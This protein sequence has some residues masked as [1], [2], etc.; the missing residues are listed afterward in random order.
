MFLSDKE[1]LQRLQKSELLI[2]PEPDEIQLGPFTI[3]CRL[4]TQ[5]RHLP[6]AHVIRNDAFDPVAAE[7]IDRFLISS[8]TVTVELGE[9]IVIQSH[10]SLLGVTLELIQTPLDLA[11]FIF[12]RSSWDRLGLTIVPSIV[13]PGFKGKLT[14]SLHNRGNIPLTLYPGIRI[15]GLAFAEIRSA[16]ENRYVHKYSP[17]IEPKFSKLN[18]DS[19]IERIKAIKSEKQKRLHSKRTS[20]ID[21]NNIITTM[22]QESG[23]HKGK[24]LE[25]LAAEIFK[26]IKGLKILKTNARLHAEELD[27]LLKNDI[28]VGFWRFAGSPI[29]VECKNWSQ[30]VGA[31]EVSVLFDKLVSLGPKVC[32]GILIAPHGLTGDSHSDAVL[33]VRE[34]RQQGR[35]IIILNQADLE[36]IA[37]GVH[38]VEVIDKKWEQLYQI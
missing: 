32:T 25:S 33:K 7:S 1:I 24:A 11:T 9:R 6:S 13:D 36:E 30:K 28:T 23:F 22:F 19:D 4:G 18:L 21:L 17:I 2:E 31:R 15:I 8:P 27:L 10:S 14:L 29:V 5:F 37:Q 16:V 20:P 12:P 3:D 34:K 38:P 26:S 35:D